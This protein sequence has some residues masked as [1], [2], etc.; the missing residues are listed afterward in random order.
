LKKYLQFSKHVIVAILRRTPVF[1]RHYRLRS[2]ID[3]ITDA[4]SLL[5][6]K[7][8]EIHSKL[9]NA[10]IEKRLTWFGIS[11]GQLPDEQKRDLYVVFADLPMQ[12]GRYE[13]LKQQMEQIPA[14][15]LTCRQWLILHEM[16]C[17]CRKYTL[18]QIF[19]EKARMLA[20]E[21]MKGDE[22]KPP[23]S[24]ENTIGA[25]IEGEECHSREELDHL[26][27]R[28]VITGDVA[29]KWHLYMAV[30]A[31][32]KI[33]SEWVKSFDGSDFANYL[34]GKSIAIV[35]PAPTEA[36]DAE[37]IDSHDIVVRLNHSFEGKGTDP[38]HKGLRTDISC[39]NGEQAESFMNERNG[40][41]PREISWGCFKSPIWRLTCDVLRY[42]KEANTDKQARAHITF[43]HPQFHGSFN[44]IPIVALDLSLFNAKSIKIYHTDLMLTV[45]RQKGYYPESF[46]IPPED[47]ERMKRN[48]RSIS[49][50]HDPIQQYRILHKLWRTKKITGDAR[51]VEVMGVGLDAYLCELE[52]MYANHHSH[53]DPCSSK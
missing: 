19:R 49:V 38:E 30:L 15:S 16:C 3:S 25:A 2:R 36:L 21:P 31:G 50:Q 27:A 40:I 13:E 41:M 4:C 24:W 9:F 43:H 8:G 12:T 17:F 28:A 32:Q 5:Y 1:R 26:L 48:F 52:R 10:I 35:G 51:F 7:R 23:I 18:A 22:V 11:F 39:F 20:I 53:A 42:V 45:A 14:D 6:E 46:N 47:I 44:M 37:E 29:N 34:A 33:P